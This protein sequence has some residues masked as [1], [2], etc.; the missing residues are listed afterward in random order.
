LELVISTSSAKSA[1][2]KRAAMVREKAHEN[3]SASAGDRLA[4]TGLGF[5]GD[6]A[7]KAV[8]GF[9]PYRSEIDVVGL[10]KVLTGQGAK[11]CLPVVVRSGAPLVFR[12]WGPGD[13]TVPG[14]WDIPVPLPQAEVVEPDILL[15][16]M[17]AFDPKGY[18]LGYGGGFYDRTIERLHTIK[19]VVT[20]GVAY[21]AQEVHEV[22]R[23]QHD[24]PLDWVLTEKG[25]MK[26]G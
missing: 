13:Q 10:L 7:G 1:A 8:S 23:Q 6:V 25:P 9:L 22:P 24:Q 3:L 11:T 18:R 5:V 14:Q 4:K 21:G 26:C 16:P 20:I 19:P 15:V 17:L 2:R 12:A